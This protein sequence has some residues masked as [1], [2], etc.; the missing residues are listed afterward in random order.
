MRRPSFTSL[1]AV[2]VT[3]K[4][5]AICHGWRS[6]RQ[7][8]SRQGTVIDFLHE[9]VWQ[10]GWPLAHT[11]I[12]PFSTIR[13]LYV[14]IDCLAA[15]AI[16]FTLFRLFAWLRHRRTLQISMRHAGCWFT[17]VIVLLGAYGNAWRARAADRAAIDVLAGK[18]DSAFHYAVWDEP[19]LWP[20]RAIAVIASSN[21]GFDFSQLDRLQAL[22]CYWLDREGWASL[23]QLRHLE[24]VVA[25][26]TYDNFVV[27]AITA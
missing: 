20:G 5:I 16:V 8:L 14:L 1:A 23:A 13:P 19:G 17:A 24:V 3:V 26:P 15:L 7:V 25:S 6:E 18:A 10:L 4:A 12:H 27:P 2:A 11:Q 22:H 9:P 21:E